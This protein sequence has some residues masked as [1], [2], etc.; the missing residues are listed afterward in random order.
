MM[1]A[2]ITMM[3]TTTTNKSGSNAALIIFLG[4]VA[5][6]VVVFGATRINWRELINKLNEADDE[7]KERTTKSESSKWSLFDDEEDDIEEEDVL[8]RIPS[9]AKITFK[10]T[11]AEFIR[12]GKTSEEVVVNI[13]GVDETRILA[14]ATSV[15]SKKF[16][17]MHLESGR[18]LIIDDG[19]ATLL[20]GVTSCKAK[21][22]LQEKKEFLKKLEGSKCTFAG[23]TYEVELS[24]LFGKPALVTKSDDNAISTVTLEKIN[25]EIVVAGDSS[26]TTIEPVDFGS[27]K[28]I[29]LSSIDKLTL[30]DAENGEI[31]AI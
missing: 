14:E 17:A 11:V 13:S 25:C 22:V 8:F 12:Y 2:M 16:K 27:H 29:V 15:V 7:P 1:N 18:W 21:V 6:V 3:T 28:V 9:G 30:V 24:Y 10:D 5:L 4:L 19:V 20:D 23:N 26:T 31:I